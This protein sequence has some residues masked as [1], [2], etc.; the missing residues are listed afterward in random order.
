LKTI[1][2]TPELPDETI[3]IAGQ[4]RFFVSAT[5]TSI[6]TWGQGYSGALGSGATPAL[7]YY[8]NTTDLSV[9]LQNSKINSVFAYSTYAGLVTDTG[10][11]YI[12]GANNN[13]MGDG[14]VTQKNVPTKIVDVDGIV[15]TKVELTAT[16]VAL[17][18]NGLI[19]QWGNND[20]Q[21]FANASLTVVIQTRPKRLANPTVSNKQF[22]QATPC[23]YAVF[24]ITTDGVLYGWGSNQNAM[25][26]QGTANSTTFADPVPIQTGALQTATPAK[27]KA[28]TT[29]V[30]VLA[31]DGKVYNDINYS[32]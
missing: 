7:Q 31:T 13:G 18:N 2:Q 15:F 8:P 10:E 24:A 5:T 9:M 14:T 1:T 6:T 25:L 12:W 30:L 22:I 29:G 26:G 4:Q 27:V 20:Y 3:A 11:I 16:V 17:T 28:Y 19:Y 23:V 32:Q 21:K